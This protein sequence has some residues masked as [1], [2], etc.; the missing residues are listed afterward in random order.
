MLREVNTATECIASLTGRASAEELPA[1]PPPWGSAMHRSVV[2]LR[3][4]TETAT[5]V[6]CLPCNNKI[7]DTRSQAYDERCVMTRPLLEPRT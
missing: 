2:A 6:C 1:P 7:K 5:D 4:S 3:R